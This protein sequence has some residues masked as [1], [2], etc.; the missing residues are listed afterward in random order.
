MTTSLAAENIVQKWWL[1]LLIAGIPAVASIIAAVIAGWSAQSARTAELQAMRIRDLEERYPI[2]NI[3][4]TNQWLTCCGTCSIPQ[5]ASVERRVGLYAGWLYGMISAMDL[6]AQQLAELRA[7]LRSDTY[8]GSIAARAQIVLW[9]HEG[10][11]KTEV[12]KM[13]GATRPTVDK[14]LQRYEDFGM[15]GLV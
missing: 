11:Q 5:R 2:A 15:E 10:Y 6:S 3:P 12:S 4:P 9:Y 7:V 8:D 1:V 14:W 13:L